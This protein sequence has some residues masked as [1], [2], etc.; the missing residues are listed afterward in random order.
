MKTTVTNLRKAIRKATAVYATVM[1]SRDDVCRVKVTKAAALDML[2]G[3][4][5]GDPCGFLVQ[6]D[7][8]VL[9]DSGFQHVRGS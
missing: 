4:P 9:I 1:F 8:E 5:G 3:M 6:D 7:G 2:R